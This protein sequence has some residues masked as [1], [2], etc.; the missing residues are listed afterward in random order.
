MHALSCV[1]LVD[2]IFQGERDAERAALARAQEELR[3]E[4]E[5]VG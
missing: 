3:K 2:W 4:N 5:N 1:F